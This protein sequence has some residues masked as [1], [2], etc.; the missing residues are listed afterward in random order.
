M[1]ISTSLDT[2]SPLAENIKK[3]F[4]FLAFLFPFMPNAYRTALLAS[5][6]ILA[7]LFSPRIFTIKDTVPIY[8][9]WAIAIITSLFSA[10]PLKALLNTK[11]IFFDILVPFAVF[12]FFSLFDR[13]LFMKYFPYVLL[14]IT[15]L[16]LI[17]YLTYPQG[18]SFFNKQH[19]LV[20]F[21]GGKLTYAGAISFLMPIL[22]F[23]EGKKK[24]TLVFL[25]FFTLLLSL[26]FNLSR[27][28]YIGAFI[29]LFLC[30][31]M[32]SK[33]LKIYY[34]A[35][36]L[37]FM[38][39]NFFNQRSLNYLKSSTPTE[40]NASVYARIEM[41]K[42]G[43]K[44]LKEKPLTGIGYELWGQH[45]VSDYYIEKYKTDNLQKVLQKSNILK[46][47]K[48]HL[49]SNYVME[50][51]N[52]GLP[53]LISFLFLLFYYLYSFAK[54]PMPYKALGI[55]LILILASAGAFEYNFS[56]AEV[57][58]NF[59]MALGILLGKAKEK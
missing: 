57:V 16:T 21:L 41:W 45:A 34:S 52:G 8:I 38:L 37:L 22:Y 35:L 51:V 59:S 48:G 54:S 5:G 26:T 49:H 31:L 17:I 43:F 20:G 40:E 7:I 44:I 28:Y 19:W 6:L 53:L 56:D 58:Q 12:N 10:N 25:S 30:L 42:L 18:F 47:I 2:T 11:G 24:N 9:F 14:T 3:V 27:S 33:T 32:F 29:F 13:E 39:M 36:I 1:K 55:G 4:T 23:E 46:A 15:T 50:A